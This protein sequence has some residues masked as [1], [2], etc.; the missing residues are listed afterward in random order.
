MSE[1]SLWL[2]VLYA[3]DF[4]GVCAVLRFPLKTTA[5]ALRSA[6]GI[7]RITANTINDKCFQKNL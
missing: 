7:L 2:S 3:F 5:N 6:F 4:A 1:L